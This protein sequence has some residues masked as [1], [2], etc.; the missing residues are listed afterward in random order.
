[1]A[2]W[3]SGFNR[4]TDASG[5]GLVASPSCFHLE[6]CTRVNDNVSRQCNYVT[7]RGW[8]T[9]FCAVSTTI[10]ITSCLHKERALMCNCDAFMGLVQF[11]VSLSIFRSDLHSNSIVLCNLSQIKIC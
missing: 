1:M 6:A 8:S 11:F 9:M 3:S 7:A 2:A 4:E 5:E 10:C